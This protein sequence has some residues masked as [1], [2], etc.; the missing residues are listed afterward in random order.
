MADSQMWGTIAKAVLSL[1]QQKMEEKNHPAP[2]PA[3]LAPPEMNILDWNNPD[4]MVSKYFSVKSCLYLP[5]WKRMATEADGL[6]DTVKS[7]LMTLCAKMDQIRELLGFPINIHCAYRPP[8]YSKLVGGTDHDVHTMGMAID[9]DG[10]PHMTCDE[11]KAKLLPLLEEMGLRMEDN[12]AG[13]HWVH[14]DTHAVV[15]NRFFKA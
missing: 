8:E 3:P 12:G 6:N 15:H 2:A 7:N 13:S 10:D 11:I 5:T 14:L 1:F 9:F 4:S